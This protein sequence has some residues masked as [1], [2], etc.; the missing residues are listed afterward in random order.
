MLNDVAKRVEEEFNERLPYL[1]KSAEI[2]GKEG[3]IVTEYYEKGDI[4]YPVNEL[5]E[6]GVDLSEFNKTEP[7]KSTEDL[8]LDWIK[9][10]LEMK[11][12]R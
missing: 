11:A 8:Y 12:E 10:D 7:F 9:K 2:A 5:T 6:A 1:V 3:K 4:V